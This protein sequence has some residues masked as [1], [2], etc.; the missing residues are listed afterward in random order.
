MNAKTSSAEPSKPESAQ[1]NKKKNMRT[2]NNAVLAST[3]L[4]PGAGHIILNKRVVGICLIAV[5]GLAF[6]VL[7]YDA[8]R[9]TQEITQEILSS[10]AIP[11]VFVLRDMIYD[12]LLGQDSPRFKTCISVLIGTWLIGIIDTL[13]Y[14][15]KRK[16]A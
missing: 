15:L 3:L 7:A 1:P 13:R 8:F 5:A 10:G 14:R 9:I 6:I 12:G 16:Q 11:N 4:F 2:E